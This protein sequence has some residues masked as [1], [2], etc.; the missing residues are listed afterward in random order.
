[1]ADSR[2]PDSERIQYDLASPELFSA[3]S[4]RLRRYFEWS[5]FRDAEDLSQETI[6][7]GLQRIAGGA[8]VSAEDTVG[9]FIGI[10]RHVRQE[11]RK[12]RK[13]EPLLF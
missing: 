1:V 7:R 13:F 12:A 6:K 8:S 3:L 5:G 11:A 4:H 10:A 2:N 9:F